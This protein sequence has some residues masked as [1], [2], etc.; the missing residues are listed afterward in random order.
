MLQ[1][2]VIVKNEELS[3][4]DFN[5]VLS[6]VK[7]E[8]KKRKSIQR[9]VLE[10][11]IEENKDC[12]ENGT[13]VKESHLLEKI[14][15]EDGLNTLIVNLYPGSEG[16]SLMLCDPYGKEV[17]TVKLPY[18]ETEFLDYLD[19]QELPPILIELLEKAKLDLFYDGCVIVEL[20]DYRKSPQKTYH[21]RTFF[22]LKPT[23]LTIVRDVNSLMSDSKWTAKDKL[24]LEAEIVLALKPRLDLDPSPE[25]VQIANRNQYN[26]KKLNNRALKR[27]MKRFAQAGHNRSFKVQSNATPQALRLFDFIGKHR[28][29]RATQSY[30]SKL[31]RTSQSI[32]MWKQRA[33][34]L[35]VPSKVDVSSFSKMHDKPKFLTDSTPEK[36]Q[37]IVLE[38]EKTNNRAYYCKVTILR[39]PSTG[40]YLGELYLEEESGGKEDRDG[41]S[42]RFS[43]GNRIAAQRYLQ[44]FQELYTEE[45]RKSVK[46]STYVA[47]Q[48][49][50]QQQQQLQQQQQQQLQQQPSSSS[51]ASIT[52]TSSQ[53]STSTH[54]ET[55]PSTKVL[56]QALPNTIFPQGNATYI[57]TN[58]IGVTPN[59]VT[60]G[61]SGITTIS[62]STAQVQSS[63]ALSTAFTLTA[64][65]N[66]YYVPASGN[67]FVAS[68]AKTI[69]AKFGN[70]RAR[71]VDNSNQASNVQ[72]TTAYLQPVVSGASV[73]AANQGIT[74]V[75]I[76]GTNVSIVPGNIG[77]QFI[78][79]GGVKSG[80]QS[81]RPAGPA[82]IA[83]L[84]QAAG[85]QQQ[86]VQVG[87]QRLQAQFAVPGNL[88]PLSQMARVSANATQ[89]KGQQLQ[90]GMAS[91]MV[92]GKQVM[93]Q[94]QTAMI[95]G[96]PTFIPSQTSILQGQT[97]VLPNGQTAIIQGGSFLLQGQPGQSF[98]A[99][100]GQGQT[101]MI[102]QGQGTS[103][104][105]SG[106]HQN[107]GQS[108]VVQGS[109]LQGQTV[110]IQSGGPTAQGQTFML[111]N[112]GQ[113]GQVSIITTSLSQSATTQLIQ[114]VQQ[115]QQQPQAKLTASLQGAASPASS[116]STA[117]SA[118]TSQVNLIPV[119]QNTQQQQ[120][121]YGQKILQFSPQ[122]PQPAK[123][124]ARRRSSGQPPGVGGKKRPSSANK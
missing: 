37:E 24:K 72:F 38:G 36:I 102:Q 70:L 60:V 32:D 50:Q 49:Q 80:T 101:V 47:N 119:Q 108:A 61:S 110:L 85:S 76:V 103:A 104:I 93:V 111:Q 41:R 7:E 48:Q 53:A 84:Q 64:S 63:S 95:Q 11:F 1:D 109:S 3:Y 34:Q 77:A 86:S 22:L 59:T 28:D 21:D 5:E 16:Y 13:T 98:V 97:T 14:V 91:V 19:A 118:L 67:S 96:Q 29:K 87:Q 33:L 81:I 83:M 74:A 123:P 78:A 55:T 62:S 120:P 30:H 92:N 4:N 114:I 43:L 113:Q 68:G 42:C 75:P 17:E 52:V 116:S 12:E 20:R 69:S 57:L 6:S 27:G 65:G 58:A 10:C 94:G 71:A 115:Q 90:P 31:N 25:V 15:K 88:L 105:L 39:R 73:S 45:G 112:T 122:T 89:Q 9:R 46:I 2:Q 18:E 23:A 99:G 121:Q 100:Q 124:S 106:Q 51:N 40:E 66:P 56:P 35:N 54:L 26:A 82:S 44:Q 79:A 107:Q 8:P 117:L